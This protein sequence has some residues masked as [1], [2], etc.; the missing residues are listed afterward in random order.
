MY[1]TEINK[2]LGALHFQEYKEVFRTKCQ[3]TA[4]VPICFL[5]S[6]SD[7]SRFRRTGI[8]LTLRPLAFPLPGPVFHER[9][10]RAFSQLS[11][12]ATRVSIH[13]AFRYI[14]PTGPWLLSNANCVPF[15]CQV[16][17]PSLSPLSSLGCSGPI[18]FHKS[19]ERWD[20]GCSV[21]VVA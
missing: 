17:V 5:S 18:R 8:C 16:E 20:D 19:Q 2:V 12:L 1:I 4:H 3:G 11:V 7:V 10:R 13:I 15:L 9:H 14:R 21:S 6:H